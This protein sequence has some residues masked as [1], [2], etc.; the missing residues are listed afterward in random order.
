[1]IIQEKMK[2]FTSAKRVFLH[3]IVLLFAFCSLL[4]NVPTA[5]AASVYTAPV[6]YAAAATAPAPTQTV[7]DIDELIAYYRD[8]KNGISQNTELSIEQKKEQLKNINSE[9]N[10]LIQDKK[11]L[12]A[13]Q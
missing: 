13:K 1:M 5:L 3:S 11:A 4:L 2:L 9:I 8:Q 10:A 12:L 6:L 7:A